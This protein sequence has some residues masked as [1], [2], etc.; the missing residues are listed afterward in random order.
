MID[1]ATQLLIQ[2]GL[3]VFEEV[4]VPLLLHL[5]F[6]IFDSDASSLCFVLQERTQR[7]T[8]FLK[9]ILFFVQL[10]HCLIIQLL[11][12]SQLL[13]PTQIFPPLTNTFLYP[14]LPMWFF[15]LFPLSISHISSNHS[16]LFCNHPCT[17][18]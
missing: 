17:S 12:L 15:L 4:V 11:T 1:T 10:F 8:F 18:I 7:K 2:L 13:H 9:K 6:Q 14:S 3:V 16:Q 5:V